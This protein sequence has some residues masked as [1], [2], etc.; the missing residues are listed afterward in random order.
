MNKE[1]TPIDIP[2]KR[3][4]RLSASLKGL[5]K[6]MKA[7]T[8]YKTTKRAEPSVRNRPTGEEQIDTLQQRTRSVIHV[9]AR[10]DEELNRPE[11]M[12]QRVPGFSGNKIKF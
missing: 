1:L 2:D 6:T 3:A 8:P 7:V 5:D 9:L 10:T 11:A 12:K 4:S